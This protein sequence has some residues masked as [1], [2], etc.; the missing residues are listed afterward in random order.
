MMQQQTFPWLHKTSHAILS[1]DRVYRYALYRSLDGLAWDFSFGD[2]AASDVG[3]VRRDICFIML[4][5][6]RA[7]EEENDPTIEKLMKYARAWGFQRLSV[8][9]LFAYRETDSTK[10]RSIASTRDIVGP[11]NN[12]HID[13]VVGESHKCVCA[14]GKQG[15]ILGRGDAMRRYL[16]P[17][18]A[19][20]WCF[21]Q[22][23]DL[24][25]VHPLYQRDAAELVEFR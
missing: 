1:E 5:P 24:S 10:L 20:L 6:S 15:E 8:V 18:F 3:F 14:W 22:N 16:L 17:R 21:K 23:L 19:P 11:D 25:P 7:S 4:N 9:N 13:R 2:D 12:A